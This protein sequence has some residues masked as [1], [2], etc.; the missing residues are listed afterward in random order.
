[1]I[2]NIRIEGLAEIKK[3][4]DQVSNKATT[5]AM[6]RALRKA[7]EPVR[8]RAIQ[9]APSWSGALKKSIN[10]DFSAEGGATLGKREAAQ[11]MREG[12][13]SGAEAFGMVSQIRRE[14]LKDS[15]S[16]VYVGPAP[17]VF[18]A[19]FVEFGTIRMRAHPFLRPALDQTRSQ[20]ISRFADEVQAVLGVKP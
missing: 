18:Y 9:N 17:R 7:A 6:S 10:I 3:G 2:F 15:I 16:Y 12:Y 13:A 14:A 1:M 19:A 20:V 4:L 11:A 8:D 5:I